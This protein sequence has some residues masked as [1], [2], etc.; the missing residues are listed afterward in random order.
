MAETRRFTELA[1]AVDPDHPD[2]HVTS[3]FVGM[4]EGNGPRA[5]HHVRKA[6]N[7]RRARPMRP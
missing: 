2:A 3:G 6:V 4:I 1:L 7:P 5:I